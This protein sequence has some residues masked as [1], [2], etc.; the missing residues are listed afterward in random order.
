MPKRKKLKRLKEKRLEIPKKKVLEKQKADFCDDNLTEQ[1][2]IAVRGLYYI[3]ETDA[4][5]QPFVGK[6]ARAVSKQEILSQTKKTA[7]STVEEKDFA[8]FFA[9]LTEIQ[10]WFGEEEKEMAQK[11][12]Q[13]KELL[14]KSLRDL[15]VFKIGEIQLDVYVVGLDA[16]DNLLGIETKAVET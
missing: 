13:L 7:D 11:F 8:G 2:K 5:I 12:V 4:L 9:R 16:E 14:E 10:D 15:K 3:S 6:P 1:I